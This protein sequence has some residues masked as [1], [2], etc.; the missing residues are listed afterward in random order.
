MLAAEVRGT[1]R[2]EAVAEAPRTVVATSTIVEGPKTYVGSERTIVFTE[3]GTAVEFLS[4]DPA[5]RKVTVL[6]EHGQ[7][8]IFYADEKAMR[9]L[10][11]V[12]P[13]REDLPLRTASTKRA[14]PKRS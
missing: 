7:E 5:T 1:M 14:R 9:S 8:Q 11:T 10:V 3:V 13:G 12:V 4:L 2:G 6:G